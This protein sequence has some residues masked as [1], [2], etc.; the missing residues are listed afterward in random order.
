MYEDV[1]VL[2]L[3]CFDFV[4]DEGER[5]TGGNLFMIPVKSQSD[6]D[7]G[8]VPYKFFIPQDE[9]KKMQGN[10]FPATAKLFFKPNLATK[11]LTFSHIDDVHAI[12]LE[13]LYE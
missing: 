4:S 11:K 7:I 3:R 6:K 8:V 12:N 9:V 1:V 2:G 10:K 5:V 13:D